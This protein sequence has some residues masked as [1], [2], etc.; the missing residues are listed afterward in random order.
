MM[1]KRRRRLLILVAILIAL[2]VLYLFE[3]RVRGEWLLASYKK[4]LLARGERLTIEELIP[5]PPEGTNIVLLTPPATQSM[6]GVS[7]PVGNEFPGMARKLS[8]GRSIVSWKR[9]RWLETDGTVHTWDD[10]VKASAGTRAR[11]PEIRQQLTNR[12]LWISLDYSEGFNLLLPHLVTLKSTGLALCQETVWNLNQGNLQTAS[13]NLH[14]VAQLTNMLENAPLL[15]EQLV[16]IAMAAIARE[17]IWEALQADGWTDAQ[18]ALLQSDWERMRFTPTMAYALAM[19]RAMNLTYFPGGANFSRKTLRDSLNWAPG[20]PAG[21]GSGGWLEVLGQ[22]IQPLLLAFRVEIWRHTWAPHDEQFLLAATQQ[23]IDVARTAVEEQELGSLFNLEDPARGLP[24]HPLLATQLD[25]QPSLRQRYLLS[26]QFLPA[27]GRIIEKPAV[28]DAWNRVMV[29]AIALKRFHLKHERWPERLVD[30]VPEFLPEIP[31]DWMDAHPLRYRL[32]PD[33]TFLLYS[34]GADGVDDGGNAE[35][36]RRANSN[37]MQTEDYVWP[38]PAAPE[39][40]NA[41]DA[42]I[43]AQAEEQSANARRWMQ[44]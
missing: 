2:P 29:T 33:G 5:T 36:T 31:V 43:I 28:N 3:E 18:L 20:L 24:V 1:R 37:W 42:E 15:I 11:L 30:L 39:E 40:V 21:G 25:N 35:S 17:T 34:V 19:E 16:R 6:L 23:I 4:E 32:N 44:Q 10:Y 7:G 14:A 12:V 22:E 41:A 8:P 13:D 26:A 27:I 38:Q 9:D